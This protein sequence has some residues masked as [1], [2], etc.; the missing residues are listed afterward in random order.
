MRDEASSRD[1]L[2]CDYNRDG[3]SFRSPW[4]DSY[5]PPSPGGPQPSARLRQVEVQLNAAF[6]TYREMYFEGGVS[7]VYLWDQD[8]EPSMTK[9]MSFAG[10]VL[11]KKGELGGGEQG[12]LRLDGP[13]PQAETHALPTT[14]APLLT[15]PQCSPL[16]LDCRD[17][18]TRCTC[19]NASSAAAARGTSSHRRSS[20]FS[21]PRRRLATARET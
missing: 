20:S 4:S 11:L 12:G 16:I 15:L 18:G 1:F 3:D 7:S 5:I 6:D 13:P 21:T 14:T 17:R 19:L 2:C 10:V 9:D 8:E